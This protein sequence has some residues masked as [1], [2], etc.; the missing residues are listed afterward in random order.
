MNARSAVLVFWVLQLATASAGA[1]DAAALAPFPPAMIVEGDACACGRAYGA[2]FRDGIRSFLDAEIYDA[3]IGKP[4]S[5]ERLLAYAAACGEVLRAEC[6]LIAAEFMGIAEGAG[7]A[8]EEIVLINLH[9]ELYHRAELPAKHSHCTAVA[10]GPP[11]SGDGHAYVGQTWDWLQSVAG[12]SA[13]VEWRRTQAASVLAYG[14]PGMPMGAGLNSEGIALC[15]TSAALETTGQSPRVGIP[16]YALIAH[17]L[18]QRDLEG[19]IRE[20]Q[21]NKHAGW[22][23]FVIAD[24]EG[25]LVNVE[26][27]PQRV[28]VE[29]SSGPLV[30]IGYGTRE[31]SGAPPDGAIPQHP[32]CALMD[33]LLRQTAGR[34]RLAQLQQYFADPTRQIN[35]GPGTID[36]M[37]FDATKR[38][39]YLSR[40]T[41][42]GLQWRRFQFTKRP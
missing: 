19:V 3:F 32:R 39:A 33:D 26:G 28:V 29:R 27:S 36:M 5:K 21:K 7:L 18:A 15:W 1:E 13:V 30:R 4:C 14:F 12:K 22:F 11:S 2:R 38:T 42:Y 41:S 9:E 20:A 17:L 23:T 16:S 24:G 6:P 8:F 25:N 37:V 34:N 35:V 10:V 31:M 40:G